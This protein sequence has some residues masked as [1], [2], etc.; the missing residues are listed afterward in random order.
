MPDTIGYLL[1]VLG[2]ASLSPLHRAFHRA[3]PFAT[4]LL[5]F[6]A[7]DFVMNLQTGGR[8]ILLSDLSFG[9]VFYFWFSS[10]LLVVCNI[11]FLLLLGKGIT[12]LL[13]ERNLPEE[14]RITTN[15]ITANIILRIICI[16][17]LLLFFAA[18]MLL[19]VLL[20]TFSLIIN[21]WL[22]VR[23]YRDYL[24]IEHVK[25]V[26]SPYIVDIIDLP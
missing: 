2:L 17:P 20:L 10:V 22:M 26:E 7:I 9:G 19:T 24:S 3:L 15:C 23:I 25:V 14:V 11:V 8:N 21:I 5:V 4:T 16:A 1:I 6:S 18:I 12:D 13:T